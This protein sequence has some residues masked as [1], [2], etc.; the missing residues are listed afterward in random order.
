MFRDFLLFLII[1]FAAAA[2]LRDEFVFTI[3]YLFTGAYILGRW[4]TDRALKSLKMKRLVDSRAFIGE[5]VPVKLEIL[6]RGWLPLVWLRLHDSLP[7]ELAS[8]GPFN[9]VVTLPPKRREVFEY[10]LFTRKRGC[11]RLGPLMASTGDV[12]GISGDIRQEQEPEFF[13]VYPRIIPL[14]HLQLPSRSPMGSMRHHQPLYEDPS[15][16]L[17]KRDYT[18][19]DSLRRIDWKATAVAGRL[20]VKQ[21]E[22]SILLETA[23][24]LNLN[25]DDYPLRT[26]IDATEL[27]IVT[28]ASISNWVVS[29]KQSV[30][31]YTNGLDPLNQMQR[32]NP[33]PIKNGQ[34]H[35]MRIL[36]HLARIQAGE[37]FAFQEMI[38]KECVQL[39]W[40]STLMM[41]TGKADESMFDQLFQV[42]RAGFSPVLI[43]TGQL[44][45]VMHVGQLAKNFEIPFYHFRNEIDLETWQ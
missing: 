18:S 11:Y 32:F 33:L 31:L 25:L 22:P 10:K 43:L 21:F 28:A 27:A 44:P 2:I 12:L 17:N 14:P 7:V 3:L 20:Q 13:T 41:I 5:D 36:D 29:K 42:Q 1:L 38:R 19:G 6:N 39:P 8:T 37:G 45:Q 34:G 4:W 16:V 9:R 35:L 26:R 24:F 40:G 23:I 30:G 15:R